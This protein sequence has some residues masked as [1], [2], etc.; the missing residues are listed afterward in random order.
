[1]NIV[2]VFLDELK[3]KV[4]MHKYAK[5][6]YFFPK[7]ANILPHVMYIY[8]SVLIHYIIDSLKLV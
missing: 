2:K 1:M 4:K 3:Y 5:G 7:I 6:K 8:N